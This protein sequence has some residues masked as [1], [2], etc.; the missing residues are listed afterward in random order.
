MD[1]IL[2]KVIT[3]KNIVQDIKKIAK[4]AG[5]NY[6]KL[7]YKLLGM[8]TYF[9]NF[10]FKKFIPYTAEIRASYYT[11]GGSLK[12]DKFLNEAVSLMQIYK[13][14]VFESTSYRNFY[15]DYEIEPSRYYTH[16]RLIIKPSSTINKEGLSLK[17]IYKELLN[18][19]NK[20]KL[21]HNILINFFA[22]K[23]TQQLKVFTKMVYAN[24]FKNPVKILLFT[25]IE[26]EVSSPSN[27]IEHY[28]LKRPNL[29]TYE[30]DTKALL[31]E[32]IRPV[33]GKNGFSA[34]GESL[35]A[36]GPDSKIKHDFTVD[37]VT[38]ETVETEQ[39]VQ[40]YAR[41]K[42][43]VSFVNEF[44]SISNKIII[45]DINRIQQSVTNKEANEVELVITQSDVTKDG[46]GAGVELKSEKIHI[47]GHIGKKARVEAKEVVIDGSTHNESLIIARNGEVNRHK[48]RIQGSTLK[49]K[50]LE[51]GEIH[52]NTVD[53]TNALSGTVFAESVH[54]HN[55]KNRVKIVASKEIIVD[56]LMGEDNYFA[57]DCSKV[58]T[59]QGRMRYFERK[60]KRLEDDIE[61]IKNSD[62]KKVAKAKAE[63]TK[64]RAEIDAMN[65]LHYKAKI[66][67]RSTIHGLNI[68]EFNVV[69]KKEKLTFR[70]NHTQ[71]FEPFCLKESDKEITL[72]PTRLSIEKPDIKLKK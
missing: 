3:T 29:Q 63:I 2:K 25:G 12:H 67:I 15:L 60:I 47:T 43:Y 70:T 40:Y 57:I 18:C 39:G 5:L 31:I 50:N 1:E 66:D 30:V 35:S 28:K 16:P 36:E 45:K 6:R 52:A 62:P 72:F 8:Q 7:D 51:G 44:L 13:V 37:K 55:L 23:M 49:I 9:K 22:D 54:I 19:L 69:D 42:G 10:K 4:D 32:Y 59:L 56:N 46:V 14:E 38:V 24:K 68:I 65:K 58:T 17:E 53:I 26:P 41:R 34:K 64:I 61:V 11:P 33:Y 27:V 48:G 71:K 20:I 21:E